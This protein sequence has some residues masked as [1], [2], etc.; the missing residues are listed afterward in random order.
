M[1]AHNTGG[2]KY[3]AYEPNESDKYLPSLF[4]DVEIDR[5]MVKVEAR[6][7][8]KDIGYYTINLNHVFLAYIH[9]MGDVWKDFLGATNEVYQAVGQGIEASKT[10]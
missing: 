10:P 7:L 6:P 2:H 5:Q 8:R 4:F 9:K 1:P 3:P